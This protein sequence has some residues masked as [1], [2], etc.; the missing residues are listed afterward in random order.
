[1]SPIAFIFCFLCLWVC[2]IYSIIACL[3]KN[4]LADM[5]RRWPLRFIWLKLS[6]QTCNLCLYVDYIYGTI[7]RYE[8]MLHVLLF[9]N[10]VRF[11][12]S[13][14][15]SLFFFFLFCVSFCIN[16]LDGR[17]FHI[18]D[19][20]VPSEIISKRYST[21]RN[22]LCVLSSTETLTH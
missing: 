11:K 10:N 1:M 3:N 16:F 19:A 15:P 4:L 2:R 13:F 12:I 17:V 18:C 8:S 7:T 5:L 14:I 20:N 9:I 21:E 22:Y 6:H